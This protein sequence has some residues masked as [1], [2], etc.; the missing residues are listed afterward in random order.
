[1]SLAYVLVAAQP[2]SSN[3]TLDDISF[4]DILTRSLFSLYGTINGSFYVDVLAVTQKQSN[5]LQKVA[6]KCSSKF[7]Y[8]RMRHLSW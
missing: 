7:V 8:L 5:G 6:L 2:L 1:M 3:S 4:K